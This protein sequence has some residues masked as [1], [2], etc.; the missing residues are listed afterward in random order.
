M[1]QRR[2][3]HLLLLA[4]TRPSSTYLFLLCVSMIP[5]L[6]SFSP[7]RKP[8]KTTTSPYPEGFA[9]SPPTIFLR[10]VWQNGFPSRQWTT[11]K[12]RV[13]SDLSCI[14]SAKW[15]TLHRLIQM[16]PRRKAL[17]GLT[18]GARLPRTTNTLGASVQWIACAPR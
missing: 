13:G 5:S 16:G 3:P 2:K 8:S 11:R 7:P 10:F 14:C 1:Q 18:A 12:R 4:C 15:T 17:C 9:L 6:K